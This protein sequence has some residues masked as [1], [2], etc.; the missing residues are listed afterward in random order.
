METMIKKE[1]K[2]ITLVVATKQLYLGMQITLNHY[3][4]AVDMDYCVETQQ[5]KESTN[6]IQ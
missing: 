2:L 3:D 6:A 1:F 4:V 5:F